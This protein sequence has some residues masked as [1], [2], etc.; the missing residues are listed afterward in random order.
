[1]QLNDLSI[2]SGS[3]QLQDL[4]RAGV[5]STPPPADPDTVKDPNPRTREVLGY[6]HGNCAHCHNGSPVSM[7]TLDLRHD[8]ALS[9]LIYVPTHSS[10][11]TVGTRV[12]PGMPE[13]SVLFLAL[14]AT[15]VDPEIK[16]MPPL[17][18][19][20]PDMTA[21]ELIR[22]WIAMLPAHLVQ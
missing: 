15:G 6:L 1:M 21:I 2:A 11:Q 14:S 3:T 16:P 10:A 18:V 19:Q 12:L 22:S 7:T 17:G 9:D 20:V 5:F 4:H 13:Q 8:H